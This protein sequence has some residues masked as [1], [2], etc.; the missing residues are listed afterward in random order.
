LAFFYNDPAPGFNR[1]A[2]RGK[3]FMI[4]KVK[5]RIHEKALE[6]GMGGKINQIV[7]ENEVASQMLVKA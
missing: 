5:D 3:M 2:V 6:I 7:V 1:K 4:F